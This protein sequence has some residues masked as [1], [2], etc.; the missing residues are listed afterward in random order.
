M[1]AIFRFSLLVVS[2]LLCSSL[3]FAIDYDCPPADVSGDCKVDFRDFA[4]LALAWLDGPTCPAGYEDCDANAINGCEAHLATSYNNCGACG[5][6]CAGLP[7]SYCEDGNCVELVCPDKWANCD[8]D[9]NNGC[10]TNLALSSNPC[11]S[12]HDLGVVRGDAGSDQ[13]QY[14]GHGSRWFRIALLESDPLGDIDVSVSF[15]LDGPEGT[16]YNLDVYMYGC[17]GSGDMIYI[18]DNVGDESFCLCWNDW[19]HLDESKYLYIRV[20]V[21]SGTSCDDFTLTVTGNT[22]CEYCM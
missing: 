12:P 5:Q 22:G 10:E 8:G 1:T 6:S 19:S 11:A 14:T 18:A 20:Y 15:E 21:Q 7:G 9:P 3:C 4:M 16:D 17:P 13:V 2:I